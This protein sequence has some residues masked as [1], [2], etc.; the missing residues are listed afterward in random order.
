MSLFEAT[1]KSIQHCSQRK[2]I[3]CKVQLGSNL[4]FINGHLSIFAERHGYDTDGWI[5]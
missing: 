3:K 5:N 1:G 4:K 2:K